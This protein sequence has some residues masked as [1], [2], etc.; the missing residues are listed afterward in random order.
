[1]RIDI[2]SS[3]P[4][5]F[6]SFFASSI[7]NRAIVNKIVKIKIH[8]LRDYSENKHKKIDDYSYGG[9]AGMVLKI[10][11]IA[12]CIQN[13]KKKRKYDT[14]IY[15]TPDGD[16]LNQ[17]KCNE[18]SQKKN[19]IILCGRYKGVDQRV[20]DLFI[21]QEISI[22]NYVL[23]GGEI[24]AAALC[25]SIIR[26]IPGVMNNESSALFDSFQDDLIAPP[27]YTRPENWNGNKVPYVLLSGNSKKI[28][29][30][31]EEQSRKLTKKKIKIIK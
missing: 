29:E 13:L 20:R 10:E 8:D 26:L 18:L 19:I 14:I 7:L 22:G 17:K 2:I 9:E 5:L 31:N 11:P 3:L 12:K 6:E 25:D 21:D 30:W 15:M 4:S 1:M 27:I 28:K 16:I 24:P 23:S